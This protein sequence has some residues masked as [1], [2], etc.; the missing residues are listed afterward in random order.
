MNQ[1]LTAT[2][3]STSASAQFDFNGATVY[4]SAVSADQLLADLA[5]FGKGN[6]YEAAASKP[7]RTAEVSA[8]EKST[9]AAI[10]SEQAAA[11]DDTAGLE[12]Q[13]AKKSAT[14]AGTTP[15][16][17]EAKADVP[18]KK[19]P[20]IEYT[21]LQKAVFALA[22]ISREAVV[23]VASAFG[24]KTFKELDASRWD[25]AL[26]AVNAKV[27]ELKTAAEVA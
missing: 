9:V 5:K 20:S 15:T 4:L 18:V 21:V 2:E 27:E 23:A 19:A 6:T 22:S 7:A 13:N 24:V 14:S 8:A 26:A 16:A 25:E 10:T 12:E 11:V 3:L 1:S 17:A